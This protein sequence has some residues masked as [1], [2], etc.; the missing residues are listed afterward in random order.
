MESDILEDTTPH[1]SFH[2]EKLSFLVLLFS[3]HV[4]KIGISFIRKSKL[5]IT[6]LALSSLLFIWDLPA[7]REEAFLVVLGS[8]SLVFMGGINGFLFAVGRYKFNSEKHKS[9]YFFLT[10]SPPPV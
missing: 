7:W 3:S 6:V 10:E 9:A 4:K 1:V 5:G 8:A 2:V